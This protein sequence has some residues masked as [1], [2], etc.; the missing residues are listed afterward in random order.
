MQTD[1]GRAIEKD[2][3]DR[4]FLELVR[5]ENS[6][7]SL[8]A[9]RVVASTYKPSALTGIAFVFGCVNVLLKLDVFAGL[10]AGWITAFQLVSNDAVESASAVGVVLA[11]AEHGLAS[12]PS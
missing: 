8:L 9:C 11:E 4:S 2:R 5:V 12:C 7:E 10:P 6:A 1:R 3:G